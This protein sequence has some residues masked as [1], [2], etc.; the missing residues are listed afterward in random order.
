MTPI[1]GTI[2]SS[3]SKIIPVQA[4]DLIATGSSSSTELLFSSI[5]SDYKTLFLLGQSADSRSTVPYSG[6]S[7]YLNNDTTSSYWISYLS[8]DNRTGAPNAGATGTSAYQSGFSV[9]SMGQGFVTDSNISGFHSMTFYNYSDNTKNTT[10]Q[11]SGG[12]ND[13]AGG[14]SIKSNIHRYNGFYNKTD[15][16]NSIKLV[17][18]FQP[19]RANTKFSLYGIKG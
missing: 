11:A 1:I 14:H 4:F 8:A 15:V 5:P 19:F 16:I 2:A 10:F 17:P 9:D 18:A 13:F 7:I 6:M 3:V 12:F